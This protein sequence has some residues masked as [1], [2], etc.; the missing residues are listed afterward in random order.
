MSVP[1]GKKFGDWYVEDTG[2]VVCYHV[3]GTGKYYE[4][5]DIEPDRVFETDWVDH[6]SGKNWVVVSD[7]ESALEYARSIV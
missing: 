6:M 7:F 5:Y 3:D 4:F 1:K 2:W